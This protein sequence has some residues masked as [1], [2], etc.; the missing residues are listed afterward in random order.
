MDGS[1][2]SSSAA[3]G[4][5]VGFAGASQ[6]RLVDR[7]ERDEFDRID[8]D[9]SRPNSISPTSLDFRLAPQPK[10]ERDLTGQHVWAQL[11]AEFHR[12][13]L[14]EAV[15]PTAAALLSCRG[16]QS[17]RSARPATSRR[18]AG[19]S[20]E[21]PIDRIW[22]PACRVCAEVDPPPIDPLACIALRADMCC[23]RGGLSNRFRVAEPTRPRGSPDTR[24]VSLGAL[25]LTKRTF[26]RAVIAHAGCARNTLFGSGL[27]HDRRR[28]LALECVG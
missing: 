12:T 9:L 26:G 23:C 15:R 13:S 22:L 3:Q 16:R 7:G 27:R 24:A 11:P 17:R 14:S 21:H 2:V 4:L 5:Q 19:E 28:K 10:R 8:L 20:F 6:V 1:G 18:I 25:R